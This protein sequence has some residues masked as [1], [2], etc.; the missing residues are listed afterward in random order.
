MEMALTADPITAEE[1]HRYG[2]VARLA[3]PGRAVDVALGLAERIARN[4]PLAVAASKRLIRA[5]QGL[6]DEEFWATQAPLIPGVF[7]SDDAREGPRAFAEK[8]PPQWSG[9]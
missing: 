1:A 7:R 5:A 8:R 4:A 9:R 3:D 2:L 6:T